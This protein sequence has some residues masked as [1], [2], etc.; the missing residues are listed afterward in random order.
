MTLTARD[1]E[2]LKAIGYEV[3]LQDG[4]G[5]LLCGIPVHHFRADREENAWLYAKQHAQSPDG[6][7]TTMAS[8]LDMLIAY[9]YSLRFYGHRAEAVPFFPGKTTLPSVSAGIE[10][11]SEAL[12]DRIT[13]KVP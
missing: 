1:I 6:M 12:V 10:G 7:K 11:T 9:G 5:L 8:K 2:K 13:W 4:Y 3:R